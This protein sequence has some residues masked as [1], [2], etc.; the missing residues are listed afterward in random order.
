MRS[1]SL[2]S[3]PD[4]GRNDRP[5]H[6][7]TA[8]GEEA[9]DSGRL[10]TFSDGVFAVAITLLV[11]NLHVRGPGHG[12]L[13]HQFGDQWPS[14]AALCV[15]F[16]VIGVIWIHHHT[17]FKRVATV[18][19]PLMAMNLMLLLCVTVLPFPTATL[20]TYLRHGGNDAHLAAAA[21]GIV[22][23]GIVLSFLAITSRLARRRLFDPLVPVASAYLAARLYGRGGIAIAAVIGLSFLSAIVALATHM[24]IAMYFLAAHTPFPAPTRHTTPT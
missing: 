4:A 22:V 15:S 6:D 18:D 7:A 5:A 11:L 14:Y 17:L 12:S 20:A 1:T 19:R 3:F 23:E 9:L 8:S 21:Y 13:L 24:M 10:E 16:F 2:S